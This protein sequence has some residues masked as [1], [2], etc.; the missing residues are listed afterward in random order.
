MSSFSTINKKIAKKAL[1]PNMS[2]EMDTTAKIE[3]CEAINKKKRKIKNYAKKNQA[4]ALGSAKK[5]QKTVERSS[6]GSNQIIQME[7]DDEL[8]EDDWG[9]RDL[10]EIGIDDLV[11]LGGGESTGEEK[12][13]VMTPQEVDDK[14]KGLVYPANVSEALV[15]AFSSDSLV[16][17]IPFEVVRD[18]ICTRLG[19]L[20]RLNL[21]ATCEEFN[22]TFENYNQKFL[23]KH[24]IHVPQDVPTIEKAM[25]LVAKLQ[26]VPTEKDPL[27]IVLDTG[28]HEIV[29]YTNE[30]GHHHMAVNVTCSH[31]T[32]VGKGK[33]QT[34]IRG[35]FEVKNQQN[36]KF[37][38]LAV[39]NQSGVGLHLAGSETNVDVLKC[40]VK[41]CDADGILLRDGA[42][43][44]ATQCE[45]MENGSGVYCRDANTKARLDDC[46]VHHNGDH[47]LYAYG[48]AV[49]DLHGT[50]TGIH[51]NKRH[52]IRATNGAKVNIH[53]PSQHNTSHDN[54]VDR[55]QEG[56][57]STANINA[58]GT[59]T[60]VVVDYTL[61]YLS[62]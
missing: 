33:D 19:Y 18:E 31:I 41:E 36:V 26:L 47:G 22:D 1:N 30:W 17:A 55:H 60:H 11:D 45:F 12:V 3:H 59:F 61:L 57:G 8:S 53:V 7:L 5:K 37:E 20:D 39:T 43:V 15:S 44:T 2:T 29:G 9:I 54:G 40:A 24:A 6:S 14:L 27:R 21:N 10:G 50:K 58:D 51:S 46:T 4:L 49:V 48:N 35:G 16:S 56:G 62:F 28:V 13:D 38:E 25:E 34:T 32:F 52:G 23:K 42:T